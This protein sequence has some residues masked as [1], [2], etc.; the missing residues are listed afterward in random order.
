MTCIQA[1]KYA[2][3]MHHFNSVVRCVSKSKNDT[4]GCCG[5]LSYP[6]QIQERR[7]LRVLQLTCPHKLTPSQ[8]CAAPPLPKT[9]KVAVVGPPLCMLMSHCLLARRDDPRVEVV[10]LPIRDGLSLIRRVA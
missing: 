2:E 9:M 5:P 10:M 1:D 6:V 4:V 8:K 3:A 7:I